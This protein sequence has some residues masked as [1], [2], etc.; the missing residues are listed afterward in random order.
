M[1]SFEDTSRTNSPASKRLNQHDHLDYL[2]KLQGAHAEDAAS[3]AQDVL[4]AMHVDEADSLLSLQQVDVLDLDATAIL[5]AE[6][7]EPLAG[8]R[9]QLYVVV[10]EE[11]DSDEVLDESI[12][13]CLQAAMDEQVSEPSA[14]LGSCFG[15]Q[16]GVQ[17]PPSLATPPRIQMHMSSPVTDVT[18]VES[19]GVVGLPGPRSLAS[20]P[21]PLMLVNSPVAALRV[22][23]GRG[24]TR[25]NS[26]VHCE[27]ATIL[28]ASREEPSLDAEL[29]RHHLESPL[30]SCHTTALDDESELD[31]YRDLLA[32]VKM[33]E[34]TSLLQSF[35]GLLSSLVPAPGAA[36]YSGPRRRQALD[37]SMAAL[38]P[39]ASTCLGVLRQQGD[40]S[41][42]LPQRDMV[43]LQVCLRASLNSLAALKVDVTAQRYDGGL[44]VFQSDGAVRRSPLRNDDHVVEVRVQ[45]S[46]Q[47][48]HS[49]AYHACCAADQR[50]S[51]LAHVVYASC[52]DVYRRFG[53]G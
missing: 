53:N 52:T 15:A 24:L 36:P 7:A 1:T 8:P 12:H 20:L 6:N 49:S 44:T 29:H 43:G 16:L 30:E 37:Q 40:G 34:Y 48:V 4:V 51:D 3:Q 27:M 22:P 32:A 2:D 33:A 19:P 31:S 23:S 11:D 10:D 38:D 17:R 35:D 18:D 42:Y 45:L 5:A 25:F 50:A 26:Y 13:A 46:R 9:P 47:Y 39:H 21:S 41:G 14:L 28:E